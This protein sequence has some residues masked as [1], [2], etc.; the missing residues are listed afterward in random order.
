MA[1]YLPVHFLL[2]EDDDD[3]ADLVME[4]MR[5]NRLANTVDRV[6]NGV[7]AMAY[8]RQEGE[9]ADCRRPDVVLLDLRMPLKDGQEVLAEIRADADLKTLPV[10]MLTSSAADAD[11][12]QAYHQHCNSYLVKPV[13]FEKFSQMIKDLNLYWS[14]WNQLPPL[15][16]RR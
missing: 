14:V 9:Y 13:D 16:P 6:S 7:E 15:P 4:E 5:E 2:A 1:D 3:H 11:R 12:H 10:V 8:L